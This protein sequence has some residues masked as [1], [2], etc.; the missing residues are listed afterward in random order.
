MTEDNQN[1]PVFRSQDVPRVP[2]VYVYRNKAG[3]VIYVGKARNLR[4]RMSS[5]FRASTMRQSDPRRRALMHSIASYEIFP[6]ETEQEALLLESRFIKQYSPRYNVDLRDDKR[7]LHICIDLTERYPRLQ[8]ARLRKDDGKMYFGPF[9]QATALRETCRF[10]EVRFGLRNCK[11]CNPSPEDKTHCLE[12]IVRDCSCPCTGEISPEDYRA[13]IDEVINILNGDC[14]AIVA[15]LDERM[16]AQAAEMKYEE[17]ASTRDMIGNL[18]S[19]LEPTRRFINETIS[20][21]QRLSNTVGMEAL[22]LELHMDKL[23][24]HIECFDMSNISGVLAVGS[25]VCFKN[26]RPATSDYRR[27]RIRNLA[28][29]DDTAFM[30]EVLTRRYGRVLNDNLP[31]PDLIVLDGGAGQLHIGVEVLNALNFPKVTLIGLAKQHELIVFPDPAQEP[32]ELPRTH[33]GLKLLQ[34]IRDEAHRFANGYHRLLRNKRIADSILSEV[35][36]IGETRC[37]QLLKQFGSV[38]NIAKMTAE[39]LAREA[40]G[41][42]LETA[43]KIIDYLTAHLG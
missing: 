16:K 26:G 35:P 28:A 40:Q 22:K 3:E 15:E 31:I 6:V 38:K 37:Q 13:R 17:A 25:M 42:G 27:Y 11:N 41:V 23:P 29:N 24:M 20:V 32:L 9:P 19:V 39:E 33:A 43:E 21:R 30:R 2:G 14:A 36:G 18:K 7:F 4:S 10:L 34:S 1:Q 5:Y 8:L 12:H